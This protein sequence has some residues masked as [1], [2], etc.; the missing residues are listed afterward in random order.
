M[1]PWLLFVRFFGQ[2]QRRLY[3]HA[4]S[5]YII[6]ATHQAYFDFGIDARA[7]LAIGIA[8]V[9]VGALQRQFI[10]ILRAIEHIIAVGSW[11]QVTVEGNGY[12]T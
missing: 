3:T 6:Y 8:K 7:Q 2:L 10:T 5:I 1:L 11:L 4:E 12:G 9:R